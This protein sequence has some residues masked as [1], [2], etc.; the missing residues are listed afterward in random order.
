M[1]SI[2]VATM[3]LF[4][5]AHA[6]EW[7]EFPTFPGVARDDGAAFS[8][9]T[10]IYF[11]TGLQ[12]GWTLA[13]DW[14][15]YDVV[16][17]W[18]GWLPVAPLPATPR[19]YSTG[20]D[21]GFLFGGTDANGAL[22]E[23]W[24]YDQAN[25]S[26]VQRSPLP[27]VGRYAA[28]GFA[29]EG[30]L[31]IAN[32]IVSGGTPTNEFWMYDI[33]LDQ[34]TQLQD[35]PGPARHRAASFSGYYEPTEGGYV[36]GGADTAFEA[37][38]D[39]WRYDL[40]S[41]TWTAIAVLPQPRY[42]A[43][44]AIAFDSNLPMFSGVV[45]GGA[46]DADT[47]HANAYGYDPASDSWVD[48]GQVLPRA[49]RGGA[50]ASASGGGGWYAS[51]YGT[52]LD[53]DLMRRAEVYGTSYAFSVPELEDAA[54]RLHPNPVVDHIYITYPEGWERAWYSIVDHTG[55]A[56]RTGQFSDGSTLDV[57]NL[58]NGAYNLVLHSADQRLRATFIKL[59]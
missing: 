55:R 51:L 18:G 23:M 26:W 19:Q 52:G 24:Q 45:V 21:G 11:G 16:G 14:Y 47:F 12:T 29:V 30:R 54:I 9:G 44:A 20:L 53:S 25:N 13:T 10:T 3:L 33:A 36:V 57:A 31:F 37:L 7:L 5:G 22:N 34:W 39:A 43:D 59:P 56:L 35:V 4:T 27:G 50:M 32:G 8:I 17:I 48:L 38:A 58:A 42:G 46:S 41:G 40:S 15:A 49:T 6:Q 2:V 28:S 1:K